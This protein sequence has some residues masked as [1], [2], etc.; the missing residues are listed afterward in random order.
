MP[1]IEDTRKNVLNTI[2]ACAKEHG[3][4]DDPEHEV[5]D[6]QDA[7]STAFPFLDRH[8]VDA[9]IAELEAEQDG[10]DGYWEE[11]IEVAANAGTQAQNDTQ[12]ILNAIFSAA[13]S[14]G[15]EDD[16]EHE[17]GDLQDALATVV[18]SMDQ[19]QLDAFKLAMI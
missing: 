14:H 10:F 5:G 7:L 2:F 11:A 9:V 4:E 17:V 19:A 15:E 1:L 13:K 3:E 12:A 8:Q 6:L 18:N 16:P